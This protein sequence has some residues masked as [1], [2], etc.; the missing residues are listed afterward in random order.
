MPTFINSNTG[1]PDETSC[2]VCGWPMYCCLCDDEE[3]T[4]NRLTPVPPNRTEAR[5]SD[6]ESSTR[7]A[8]EHDG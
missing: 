1:F 2:P 6:D 5:D 7:A 3:E 4:E 8:G